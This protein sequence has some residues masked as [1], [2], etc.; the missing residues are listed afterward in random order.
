MIYHSVNRLRLTVIASYQNKEYE[1]YRFSQTVP[2]QQ[3]CRDYF[4]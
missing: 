1:A 4:R 2:G 3:S